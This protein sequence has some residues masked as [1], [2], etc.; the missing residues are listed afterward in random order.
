MKIL[1]EWNDGAIALIIGLF[2]IP[3]IILFFLLLWLIKLFPKATIFLD[4]HKKQK[5]VGYFFILLFIFTISALL[6][7]GAFNLFRFT[8]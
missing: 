5:P 6:T 3:S 8:N 1:S 2:F 4:Y 7:P